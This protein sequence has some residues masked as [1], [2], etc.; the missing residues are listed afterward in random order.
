MRLCPGVLGAAQPSSSGPQLRSASQ[1]L[2][3]RVGGWRGGLRRGGGPAGLQSPCPGWAVFQAG[4]GC[5]EARSGPGCWRR[6]CAWRLRPHG[7]SA[8]E[9]QAARRPWR[10]SPPARSDLSSALRC[11]LGP[12]RRRGS[13][14][15]GKNCRKTLWRRKSGLPGR[16]GSSCTRVRRLSKSPSP[17]PSGDAA[18]FLQ[19]PA[20]TTQAPRPA[21]SEQAPTPAGRLRAAP[22]ETVG[23]VRRASEERGGR[24]LV[25][26]IGRPGWHSG[27][28]RLQLS[29]PDLAGAGGLCCPR[30]W[31]RPHS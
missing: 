27:D 15:G 20:G 19:L 22:P 5:S 14:D 29:G 30:P 12:R 26:Q 11:T 23:G 28:D 16:P 4:S 13:K 21:N 3:R 6:L 10:S 9:G 18:R 17:T 25:C 7:C 8:R 2:Q 1:A 31:P 24:S